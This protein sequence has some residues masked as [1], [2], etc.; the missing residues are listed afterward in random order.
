[1]RR[2]VGGS[3]DTTQQQYNTANTE[4]TNKT[5]VFTNNK[6]NLLR[7]QSK[8]KKEQGGVRPG[9]AKMEPKSLVIRNCR[10]RRRW[11]GEVLHIQ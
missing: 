10:E 5:I 7:V 4:D 6:Q 11:R 8:D 9:E 1:M 2:R 3:G